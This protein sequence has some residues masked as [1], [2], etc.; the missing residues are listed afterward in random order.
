MLWE[1]DMRDQ[2]IRILCHISRRLFLFAGQIGR[3]S[4][5]QVE[6]RYILIGL[7]LTMR[8]VKNPTV[9]GGFLAEFVV[10]AGT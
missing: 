2:R 8:A 9:Q 5:N 7:P 6:V 1:K 3:Q 4:V 10:A